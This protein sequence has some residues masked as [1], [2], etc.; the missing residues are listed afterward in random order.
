M[1]DP[2]EH[3]KE[4]ILKKF[5]E[6]YPQAMPG[7]VVKTTDVYWECGCWSEYTRDDAIYAK[8]MLI[9]GG[10]EFA[11]EYSYDLPQMIRDMAGEQD[12]CRIIEEDE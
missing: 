1:I 7:A 8:A 6:D 11:I 5:Y 12:N 4:Y 3:L 2:D 10:R 9:S